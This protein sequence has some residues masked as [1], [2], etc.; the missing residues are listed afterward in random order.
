HGSWKRPVLLALPRSEQ[1]ITLLTRLEPILVKDSGRFL[2]EIIKLRL[3]IDSEPLAKLISRI[4]PEVS[5]PV[6]ASD[7][8]VP[9]GPA[10]FLLVTWLAARAAALPAA[11][12][13]DITKVFQAWLISTQ[14]QIL[15]LNES[16]VGTLFEWLALLEE[17]MKP[18]SYAML[19]DVPPGLGIPHIRGV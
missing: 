5:I 3:A 18:R 8:V 7:I 17:E 12:I 1:A 19:E 11:L 15:P 14:R 2:S 9:K 4:R 13:P 16:I 6:G 10:W